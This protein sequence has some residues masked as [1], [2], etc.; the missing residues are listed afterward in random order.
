MK[1]RLDG[2]WKKLTETVWDGEKEGT[3]ELALYQSERLVRVQIFYWLPE[4]AYECNFVFPTTD[5]AEALRWLGRLDKG[6]EE[7]LG[8]LMALALV[9]ALGTEMAEKVMMENGNNSVR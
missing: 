9:D 2:D 4:T 6:S 8:D 1:V 7:V 3:I 5:W